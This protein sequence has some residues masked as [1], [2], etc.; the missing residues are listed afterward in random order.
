[1]LVTILFEPSGF[2]VSLDR[3]LESQTGGDDEACG[4]G[5]FL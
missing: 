3:E 1:M 4:V 2:L 5:Y